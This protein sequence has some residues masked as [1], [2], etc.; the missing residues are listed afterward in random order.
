MRSRYA[1]R[2]DGNAGVCGN[3]VISVCVSVELKIILNDV[4]YISL[5]LDISAAMMAIKH[6]VSE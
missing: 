6:I 1:C 3:D 2:T 4:E 5:T